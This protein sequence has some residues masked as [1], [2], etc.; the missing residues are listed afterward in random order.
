MIFL[1]VCDLYHYQELQLHDAKWKWKG[2]LIPQFDQLA[3][4]RD[5]THGPSYT[6]YMHVI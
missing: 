2:K 6:Y 5:H 1:K 4:I 3:Y